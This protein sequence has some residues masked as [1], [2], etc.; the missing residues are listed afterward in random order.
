M[1]TGFRQSLVGLFKEKTANRSEAHGSSVPVY[2]VED[3]QTPLRL[4]YDHIGMVL[5][6]STLWSFTAL[7][8]LVLVSA[9]ANFITNPNIIGAALP[10]TVLTYGPATA[11][12]HGVMAQI[13]AGEDASVLDFFGIGDGTSVEDWWFFWL[14]SSCCS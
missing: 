1:T 14:P 4:A 10:L 13:V 9:F 6:M 11:A 5:V 7:L 3:S 2:V 12:V 8:P